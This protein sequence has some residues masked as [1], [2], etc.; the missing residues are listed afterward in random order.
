MYGNIVEIMVYCEITKLFFNHLGQLLA[1][2]NN[3]VD[4]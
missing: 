4:Q 2:N 1:D 3:F